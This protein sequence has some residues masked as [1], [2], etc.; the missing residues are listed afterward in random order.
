MGA[1]AVA[2]LAVFALW[3][4]I[5]SS[6]VEKPQYRVVESHGEIEIRQYSPQ[7]VAEVVTTGER[8]E[9]IGKGFRLLADFIFGNNTASGEIAMT[10]PVTQEAGQK[11][12]M[13]APVTQEAK[14]DEWIVRFM[15]PSEYT[16]DTLPRPNN[17]RVAI[18]ETQPKT[19]A[20]IRFTGNATEDRIEAHET[21]LEEFLL[22]KGYKA[23]QSASYAFYNPP[24]TLPFLKRNEVL[25]E[26]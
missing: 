24:W 12:D 18:R 8:S 26:L 1:L 9:A 7:V 13:T 6:N 20:A 16:I 2:V 5:V 21:E 17:S 25:I 11:I 10:A 19:F 4:P 14:G 3:G 15:M 23:K 22:N